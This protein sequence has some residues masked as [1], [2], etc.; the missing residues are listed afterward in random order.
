MKL[1]YLADCKIL[2][3]KNWRQQKKVIYARRTKCE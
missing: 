2:K 3:A 1:F